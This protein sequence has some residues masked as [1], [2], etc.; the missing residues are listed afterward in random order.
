MDESENAFESLERALGLARAQ[1]EN[2]SSSGGVDQSES[3]TLAM[4][5]RITADFKQTLK[6]KTESRPC[7]ASGRASRYGQMIK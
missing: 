5:E 4:L 6:L 7:T 2:N 3:G 1:E